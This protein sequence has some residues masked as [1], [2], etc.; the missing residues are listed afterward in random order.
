MNEE[1]KKQFDQVQETLSKSFDT[2]LNDLAQKW[3]DA[4]N[5]RETQKTLV[6]EINAEFASFKETQSK[7]QEQTDALDMKLQKGEATR[8][9]HRIELLA[10]SLKS[11]EAF[12]RITK[13]ARG[14]F[15]FPEAGNIMSL[16]T[17]DMTQANSFE[18]TLVVQ[19][20]HVPGIFYNP[21][22]AFRVRNLM[23]VGVTTSNAVNVV[24]E[25]AYSD[26]T[27]IKAEGSE[28]GQSDFDLKMYSATV[29]KITAYMIVSEEMLED[30]DGLASYIY[31][32][33]PSKLGVKENN[34]LLNGTGS[35]EISGLATNATAYSDNLADTYVQLIDVLADAVRQVKDDEY[36]PSAILM[37]PADV[38]KY[39]LLEKEST[40]GYIAPWIFTNQTPT[41]AGVPVIETT[42]V[43]AGT[44]FVG[45][46]Q[47]A[48]Q[49][50][51]RRQNT[52][53]LSNQNEDNF[54]KGMLTVRAAERLAL[55]IYRPSAFIYGSI[56]A[57][58]AQGSS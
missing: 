46:F 20:D 23:P 31:S 25:E 44:F 35:S 28:Y 42:A 52:I 39:L 51:D 14:D 8:G 18:S 19:P 41:I 24:R 38:T 12:K 33:L 1:I 37:H 7:L 32:R 45:D 22:T 55:A 57:T 30:V 29:Y 17:D 5:D 56:A 48:A 49:V 53:E 6:K 34:Q 40:Y 10:D 36:M 27:A 3:N 26:G 47:R 43:T 21:D 11:D 4:E 58:L 13:G 54:I 50:F 16:K 15:Q 2:K 9:K